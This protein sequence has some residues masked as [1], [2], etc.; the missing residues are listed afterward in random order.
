MD[1]LFENKLAKEAHVIFVNSILS[2]PEYFI[3]SGRNEKLYK[4]Y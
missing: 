1:I 4:N 3:F 2:T